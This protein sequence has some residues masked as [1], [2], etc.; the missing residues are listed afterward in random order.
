[1]DAAEKPTG[2]GAGRILG[3]SCLAL[4]LG[5]VG[6][7][8]LVDPFLNIVHPWRKLAFRGKVVALEGD[9]MGGG[10]GPRYAVVE[11]DDGRRVTIPRSHWMNEGPDLGD[12]V[13]KER[14]WDSVHAG[15][16]K[17]ERTV[18]LGEGPMTGLFLLLALWLGTS[19]LFLAGILAALW[20]RRRAAQA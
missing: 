20:P 1:M 19:T 11:T 3:G 6:A 5:A 7:W 13:S 14:G 17:D 9:D 2:P 8:F 12:A 10:F 18:G 15:S 4:V 16:G